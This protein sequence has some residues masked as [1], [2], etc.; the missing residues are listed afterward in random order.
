[1]GAFWLPR[2][3][4]VGAV[5]DKIGD[6]S[7][8]ALTRPAII[9]HLPEY[10]EYLDERT[11]NRSESALRSIVWPRKQSIK[12]LWADIAAERAESGSS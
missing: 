11:T 1:M 7:G 10:S 3:Q 9:A 12:A 4:L 8:L 2:I 6:K 5:G